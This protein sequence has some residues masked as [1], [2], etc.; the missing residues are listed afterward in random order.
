[1]LCADGHDIVTANVAMKMV[2]QFT[3][4]EGKS[5]MQAT[6]LILLCSLFAVPIMSG[7]S[8]PEVEEP[9]R[10]VRALE[11]QDST[12]IN[13]RSFTGRARAT[14][15]VNLAFRVGGPLVEYPVKIGQQ[16]AKGDVLAKID[17]N[18]FEVAVKNDK[19]NLERAKAELAAM[20]TGARP[21]E[22]VKLKADLN[23]AESGYQTAL[24]EFKRSQQLIK[25]QV[26]SQTEYDIKRQAAIRA[27]TDWKLAQESLNIGQSGARKED[28]D[29][30]DA[31]IR[32]LEAT[33]TATED[34]LRYTELKAPFSGII[35]MTYVE[36]FETVQAK[37][38]ILRLLDPSKIEMVIDIPENL[39]SA[40]PN[41]KNITCT[42]D[43]FPDNPITGAIIKEIGKEASETTRTYPVT[44]IM[45]QPPVEANVMILP[46][47]AGRATGRAQRPDK[48]DAIGH[49]IPDT[50][51]FIGADGKESVWV[52]DK[53]TKKVSRQKVKTTRPGV[54]GIYVQGLTAGQSIATAGVNYL[55]E[56]QQVTILSDSEDQSK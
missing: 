46:G 10:P 14:A 42:F 7:C 48:G 18:D 53:S 34:Q 44:L 25:T 28:V 33:L 9:I 38:F 49:L 8:Q 52:I 50:A 20:K 36:N 12:A 35:A 13:G 54:L 23:R 43:A 3:T 15:E 19:A 6:R 41:V 26:I 32:S 39:I 24:A 22:I 31:E 21:E 4:D 5:I 27:Q 37:Q 55:N 17:P 40:A 56:G 16:V 2:F 47:M 29:A 11:I 30:K 51:I 45:D 1:M